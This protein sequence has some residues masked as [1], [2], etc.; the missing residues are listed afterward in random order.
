LVATPIGNLE[1]ITLRALRIL[2]EVDL[3]ACEDTRRTRKLLV[4]YGIGKRLTSYYDY[5]KEKKTPRLVK[6]LLQ[7][8]SLALVSDAGTPGISDPAFYLV[9]SAIREGIEITPI[10]GPN[11]ALSALI[12]SGLPT[13]RFV[14]EGFLPPKP[15]P[16]RRRL[17]AMEEEVRTLIFYE[18]PYRLLATLED[19]GAIF[20]ERRAALAKELTKRFERILRGSIAQLI[21]QL[22]EGQVKGEWVILVEG[23]R[24]EKS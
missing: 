16:R 7:G 24:D 1:D 3:I 10:P 13:D 17:Q 22:S 20:G 2:K 21:Q 23:R 8:R 9:R 15:G 5:N 6:S 14:F 11:A 4:H 19:M 12:S 18:S